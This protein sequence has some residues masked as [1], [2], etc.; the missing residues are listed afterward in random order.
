MESKI[1]QLGHNITLDFLNPLIPATDI[2]KLTESVVAILKSQN[3][4]VVSQSTNVFSTNS[5]LIT[6]TYANGTINL[7]TFNSQN[8][9]TLTAFII[10]DNKDASFKKANDLEVAFCDLLGWT[11]NTGNATVQ[12]GGSDYHL[13]N[14]YYHSETMYRNFKLIHREQTKFQDLRIYDTKEMGRV[15]SLDFMIQNSDSLA[16]DSYTIDLCSL[17]ITKGKTYNHILLIGAGD[18]IIPDYI[19]KNFDVKKITMVEIDDRV[20]EN[21]KTYFPKFYER[22]D[23]FIKEGRLDVIV[24]DGAKYL[25]ENNGQIKFDG[26]IIDNSDVYLFDGP[27]ANLFTKE[28]YTNISGSLAVG[29]FFSQQ[30]SDEQVKAKWTDMVKSVGFETLVFKY[31]STPEYS[32]ALPLGSARK[33]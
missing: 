18:M 12:L 7:T 14:K 15:L 26:V 19:L 13:L 21:T 25:R 30:V 11:N 2:T 31:S 33:D 16:E 27:A 28:F 8:M 5:T 20:I 17:V 9:I 3:Y 24:D 10:N 32:T 4:E 23:G 1:P 29:G 22:I 6:F